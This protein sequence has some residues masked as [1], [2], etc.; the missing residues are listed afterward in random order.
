M[1]GSI[2]SNSIPILKYQK[3]A[4]ICG[5]G[6]KARKALLEEVYTTPK[7]GLVDL[8]SNGAHND[9]DVFTFEKSAQALYPYFIKMAGMGYDMRVSPGTLFREVRKVGIEA[10]QEMFRATGGVNT[11]KGLLFTVG[12]FCA[13][14]GRCLREDGK[15]TE[16]HLFN[17][18]QKMVSEILIRECR[19]MEGKTPESHGQKNLKQY[20]TLGIRGEAIKGYPSVQN[21][22]LPVLRQGIAKGKDWNLVKLQTL[23]H[24]MCEVEDSNIISRQNPQTL[25]QVQRE[26]AEFLKCGGAYADNAI[27]KLEKM[28]AD[29]IR[30]NISAGGCADLL[31]AAVFIES[32]LKWNDN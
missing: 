12:I 21:V 29:Y 10:E 14:A 28:D 30:R 7:P 17:M 18:E 8:Y 22:A 20:G 23:F 4:V 31:A 27:E 15:I 1:S 11:H 3:M 26:A 6:K 2:V 5:I 9:M 13:A 19:G 32:L 25:Y 16:K 24:L